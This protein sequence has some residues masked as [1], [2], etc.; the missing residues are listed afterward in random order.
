MW[1]LAAS[2]WPVTRKSP[3]SEMKTSRPQ[4]LAHC[5]GST[6]QPSGPV[7]KVKVGTHARGKVRQ[8]GRERRNN[9][10]WVEARGADLAVH[11][12]R[13]EC[14]CGDK[15]V[16]LADDGRG[17]R[18]GASSGGLV[19]DIDDHAEVLGSQESGHVG[20]DLVEALLEPRG[21]L[22]EVREAVDLPLIEF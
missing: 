2:N 16:P 1:S 19:G 10:D 13:C 7:L 5:E 8:A 4:V 11:L 6:R 15:V 12:E 20:L 18:D 21:G 14:E 17:E 22:G 3:R 9:L